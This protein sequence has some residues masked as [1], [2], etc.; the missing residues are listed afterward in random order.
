M[1]F[2][3]ASYIALKESSKGLIHRLSCVMLPCVVFNEE[4]LS[5]E[6]MKDDE[7]LPGMRRNVG[8]FY[9]HHRQAQ[10]VSQMSL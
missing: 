4:G 8:T 9:A 6:R 3:V 7:L 10:L 5:F 1:L 2:S